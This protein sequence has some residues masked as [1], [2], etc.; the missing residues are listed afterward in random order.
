MVN[1][2]MKQQVISQTHLP[3]TDKG[4]RQQ[5]ISSKQV[6][7]LC[8][9]GDSSK[10]ARTSLPHKA[11]GFQK[12][13]CN[14]S[15]TQ[16]GKET[17]KKSTISHEHSRNSD[18]HLN[19]SDKTPTQTEPSAT[20]VE[21]FK[22]QLSQRWLTGLE[23]YNLLSSQTYLAKLLNIATYEDTHPQQIYFKPRS[24]WIYFV[25]VRG[26]RALGFPRLDVREKKEY[27]WK[28]MNFVT[29]L[30]KREPLVQYIVA[31]GS[32]KSNKNQFRMHIVWVKKDEKDVLQK[33]SDKVVTILC[34]ILNFS[35][36][37]GNNQDSHSLQFQ[38]NMLIKDVASDKVAE[39]TVSL[40]K[41][42][43]KM[44]ESRVT[45]FKD[46]KNQCR[47]IK[48]EATSAS[49]TS[50]RKEDHSQLQ[51]NFRPSSSQKENLHEDQ[52]NN[53]SPCPDIRDR[54]LP[55]LAQTTNRQQRLLSTSNSFWAQPPQPQVPC[56]RPSDFPQPSLVKRPPDRLVFMTNAAGY[57]IH[58]FKADRITP[59][60]K[61]AA[62]SETP[63]QEPELPWEDRLARLSQ[64]TESPPLQIDQE[65]YL[66]Y[67]RCQ[68]LL[69][70]SSK[71]RHLS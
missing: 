58:T 33:S 3:V 47:N 26:L 11:I 64:L 42:L 25:R 50:Q 61:K 34:H 16:E 31:S 1:A 44:T 2:L 43:A 60:E 15:N 32:D 69:L 6:N 70:Q 62:E 53:R 52:E 49:K 56:S 40:Q 21:Y 17:Q 24:G 51:E 22:H 57:S 54:P 66:M 71:T 23:Y 27:V 45:I 8:S 5:T 10:I 14:S 48:Q 36:S 35:E 59:P 46:V 38:E 19:S 20:E 65:K 28:R 12:E 68:T 29:E 67:I 9:D 18:S 39:N 63:T 4:N 55:Q 7:S 30:P 13:G 37:G 41:G